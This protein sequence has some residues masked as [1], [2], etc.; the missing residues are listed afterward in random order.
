MLSSLR[1]VRFVSEMQCRMSWEASAD[2]VWSWNGL[3]IS[4]ESRN[5]F[6]ELLRVGLGAVI[7]RVVGGDFT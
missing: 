5:G 7:S 6:E 4:V 3:P 2:G 1:R